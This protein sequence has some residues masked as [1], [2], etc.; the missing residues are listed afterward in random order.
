M[1]DIRM[2]LYP[3][4]HLSIASRYHIPK[5]ACSFI[6]RPTSRLIAHATII[7]QPFCEDS[8][9]SRPSLF[10]IALSG[11]TLKSEHPLVI[12]RLVEHR[13][14]PRRGI[15]ALFKLGRAILGPAQRHTSITRSTDFT[16][17]MICHSFYPCQGLFEDANDGCLMR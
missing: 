17:S 8:S 6:T 9:R 2:R 10:S 13:V 14:L 15:F 4:I 3:F 12:V 16:G 1:Y 7:S 5:F 11:K